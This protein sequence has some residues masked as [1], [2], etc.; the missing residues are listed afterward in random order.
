M[1]FTKDQIKES[2]GKLAPEQQDWIMSGEVSEIIATILQENN[3]VGDQAN[4][5]DGEI[6]YALVGL[7]SLDSAINN[8]A[9]ISGRNPNDLLKLKSAIEE[10]VIN[11]SENV[12]GSAPSKPE[13]N[14][15]KSTGA[16]AVKVASLPMVEEGEKV[17]DAPHV[18]VAP[19][20]TQPAPQAQP[21]PKVKTPLPDYRYPDGAD[22][23]REPLK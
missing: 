17:H 3:L 18:E 4:L 21:E 1:A 22:P 7:Q 13:Q 11:N 8:I 16:T 2:Y 10:K 20:P 6:F 12:G 15:D 14:I 23:Y 19:P 9:T 5:S